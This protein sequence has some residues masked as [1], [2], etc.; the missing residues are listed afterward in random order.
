MPHPR[1]ESDHCG[2]EIDNAI[3]D[4]DAWPELESDHCG[5][6]INVHHAHVWPGYIVRIE[7]IITAPQI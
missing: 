7:I 5:I 6:E 2:I 4:Q 1:L 3:R